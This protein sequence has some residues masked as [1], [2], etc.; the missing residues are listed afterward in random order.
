M[1]DFEIEKGD[2]GSRNRRSSRKVA[3][4]DK[5]MTGGKNGDGESSNDILDL[6]AKDNN[7]RKSQQD[8]LDMSA[9]EVEEVETPAT[10]SKG[11]GQK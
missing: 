9:S 8:I 2:S 10:F 7:H 5:K 1:I 4:F 6:M 11:D 3:E